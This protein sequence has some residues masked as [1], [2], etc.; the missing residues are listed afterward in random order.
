MADG[1]A[2]ALEQDAPIPLDARFACGRGELLALVGPSG[3]GKSTIL[4]AVAGLRTV[5][6]G[7]IAV[8]GSVWFDAAAR[9]DVAPHRRRVGLVFQ[10]YALF[11]HMTA[12]ANIAAAMDHLPAGVRTARARALIDLVRLSGLEARRP[13]ELSGGQQQRVAVARALAREPDVLLLDE[14]FSAVDRAT[15]DKLYGELADMRRRLSMPIVLVTHD[16]EEAAMLADRMVLLH[17]GRCLQEGPPGEVT[18]RPRDA[19]VA[20]LVGQSN[21]FAGEVAAH[22]PAEQRTLLR[23]GD[24][25]LEASYQPY[26]PAGTHVA[27]LVRHGGVWLHRRDRPSH[28][29]RENPV[30]GIIE[31]MV[32]LGDN[33]R[34]RMRPDGVPGGPLSFSVSTHAARRNALAIGAAVSVSLLPDGIH[35]MPPE[36]D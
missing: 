9:I 3:S 25:M 26:F 4:R 31:E 32:V 27:W 34:L 18:A 12:L 24:R 22:R 11:P 14:P 8:G 10:S 21:I 35:L 33:A 28:G 16:L 23:W 5:S 30:A 1:L 20:R 17:H 36:P 15:R 19:T 6:R 7:R 13:A 29:E 2:V